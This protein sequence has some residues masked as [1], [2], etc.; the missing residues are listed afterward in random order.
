M[1]VGICFAGSTAVG[2][3][4]KVRSSPQM[5]SFSALQS[6]ALLSPDS[7]SN[8]IHPCGRPLCVCVTSG[9]VPK[10]V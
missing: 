8:R 9:P 5:G 6:W 1:M 2:V 3:R 10:G 4:A 7:S